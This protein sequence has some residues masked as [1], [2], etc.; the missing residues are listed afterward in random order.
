[1]E[2]L[3]FPDLYCPFPFQINKYVD[4]LEDYSFEWVQQ[5]NLL[6][7]PT[8]YQHFSKAKFFLLASY[9]YP[10]CQFEELKIANDWMSWLFVLDDQCDNSHLGQQPELLKGLHR[11]FLEIL[12]GAETNQQD[13]P[14]SKALSNLRQ[15]MLQ[16]GDTKSFNYF[17]ISVKKYFDGCMLE[18]INRASQTIPN[19]DNYEM[20]H[21]L[22]S[23]VDISID[24][25]EFC[26]HHLVSDFVRNHEI[27]N[28]LRLMTNKIICWC[29]DIFSVPKEIA[30]GDVHN[31]IIVLHYQH[32]IPLNQAVSIVADMHNQ[33][34]KSFL[35]L[36]ATIP[37][38]KKE[39][40]D[41]VSKYLSGLHTW[42]RGN[43]DW[44]CHSGRYQTGNIKNQIPIQVG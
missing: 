39:I 11:R 9:T 34:L 21:L 28:R 5:F 22:S 30:N 20:I 27:I 15:R 40:N 17:V 25:G 32:R 6:T 13:I 37:Y 1:M 14:L 31:S 41:E 4:V 23:A 44:S 33:E 29:N 7:N 42:I 38:F 43:F 36:Q 18:A 10:Y 26:N 3:V 2:K 8:E 35:D 12:Y 24:L 16:I 19:L